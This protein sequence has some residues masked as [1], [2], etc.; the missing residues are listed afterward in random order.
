M[1][2]FTFP[3]TS[4]QTT[5]NNACG[6]NTNCLFDIAA[7]LLV[8]FGET[9]VDS[10]NA[11]EVEQS[12]IGSNIMF[13]TAYTFL[14]GLRYYYYVPCLFISISAQYSIFPRGLFSAEYRHVVSNN[15]YCDIHAFGYPC[16]T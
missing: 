6:G 12:I 2:N 8:S 4:F 16:M 11:F 14:L 1:N 10:F 13:F 3:N 7:T 5:A 15:K 9:T